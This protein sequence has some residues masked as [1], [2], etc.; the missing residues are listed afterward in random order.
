MRGRN[1]NHIINLLPPLGL[2]RLTYTIY[3]RTAKGRLR[4]AAA[5]SVHRGRTRRFS[6]HT[7]PLDKPFAKVMVRRCERAHTVVLVSVPSHCFTI[8]LPARPSPVL[9]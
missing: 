3:S 2:E 4:S 8:H 1:V 6:R 9:T 5:A 7:V